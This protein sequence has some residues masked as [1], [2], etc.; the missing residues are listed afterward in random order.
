MIDSALGLNKSIKRQLK[1]MKATVGSLIVPKPMVVS[2]PK[3]G[4]TWIA[5]VLSFYLRLQ[6]GI[7]ESSE[8][9]VLQP[10]FREL[11]KQIGYKPVV[12]S[13]DVFSLGMP[14]TN[15]HTR[16]LVNFHRG[17]NKALL[18]RDPRDTIVSLYWHMRGR[19]AKSGLPKDI[20]IRYFLENFD[21]GLDALIKFMNIWAPATVSRNDIRVYHYEDLLGDWERNKR[22][23]IDLLE[24][25]LGQPVD[26]EKLSK[27]V[28]HFHIEKLK[29]RIEKSGKSATN[30]TGIGGRIREGKSG[31]F[32][33]YLNK[34]DLR[35]IDARL[36]E[37]LNT[38]A[39]NMISRYY[40]QPD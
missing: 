26:V 16:S 25:L 22:T 27:S 13:H 24:Y 37:C 38:E 21:L 33:E 6:A 10:D 9:F 20:T 7:E 1:F 31:G 30:L 17:D 14:I 40:F 36:D 5:N 11:S 12:L 28:E 34:D 39:H 2:Y 15:W 3:C 18:V 35:F 8:L 32:R 29:K 4:R 19:E 23:W